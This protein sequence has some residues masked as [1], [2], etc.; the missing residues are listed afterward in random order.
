[1]PKPCPFPQS[2]LDEVYE[3]LRA[4]TTTLANCLQTCLQTI[5]NIP[6]DPLAWEAGQYQ[7]TPTIIEAAQALYRGHDVYEI[8]RSML[9][10]QSGETS[11]AIDRIIEH[12]KCNRQ[13]AICFI[14]GVPGAGKTLAGLNIANRRLQFG[15]DEHAVFLSGNGPLVIV[16]REALVRDDISKGKKRKDAARKAETFIQNIH[17]FRDEYLQNPSAP[18]NEW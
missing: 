18:L 10:G 13:K 2:L 9:G 3:P 1:M 11:D 12:V 15:R 17:R 7:P 8:S 14:T 6:I 5:P 16:L 4:N